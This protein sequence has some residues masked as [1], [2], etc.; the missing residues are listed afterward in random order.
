MGFTDTF[1]IPDWLSYG[2]LRASLSRV[3]MGTSAYST[4][5]GFGVFSQSAQYDPNRE[6]VLIANPNLGTAW[7]ND[8]KPEIQ[9]SIELGADLRFF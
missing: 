6:S 9:Q 5:R 8:L 4:T 3:G 7:N 1:D 2:K